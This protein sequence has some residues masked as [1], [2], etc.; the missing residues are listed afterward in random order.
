MATLEDIDHGDWGRTQVVSSIF[1]F[2]NSFYQQFEWDG[3]QIRCQS[4]NINII[5]LAH[6]RVPC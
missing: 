3:M 1:I 2:I 4:T 6:Q 5:I